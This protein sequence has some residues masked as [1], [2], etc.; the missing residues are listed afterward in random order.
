VPVIRVTIGS[1]SSIVAG[2]VQN[3]CRSRGEIPPR[4]IPTLARGVAEAVLSQLPEDHKVEDAVLR[5]IVDEQLQ[6]LEQSLQTLP[7]RLAEARAQARRPQRLGPKHADDH[8]TMVAKSFEEKLAE[9]RVNTQNLLNQDC[10]QL[11]LI[12]P[13]RATQMCINLTGKTLEHA[14]GEIIAELRNILHKQVQGYIRELNGGPW[15]TREQ[16]E[17]LRMEIESTRTIKSVL[18]I[19][20]QVLRERDNWLEQYSGKTLHSLLKGKIKFNK[21]PG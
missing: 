12:S 1:L 9:Y 15:Q 17:Q 10:V 4:R 6:L 2:R 8:P 7:K 21:R 19:T 14:E 18:G 20:R 3:L 5:G 16:R 13:E 11:G